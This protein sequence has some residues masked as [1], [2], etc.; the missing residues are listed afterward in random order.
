[1]MARENKRKREEEEGGR[2]WAG[3]FG[4]IITSPRLQIFASSS[5]PSSLG[6]YLFFYFSISSF[7]F[8]CF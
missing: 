5:S 3:R 7:F 2:G 1:M 8:L 6:S 4:I